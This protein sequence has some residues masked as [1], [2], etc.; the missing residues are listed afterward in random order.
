MI[1]NPENPYAFPAAE[2]MSG[3]YGAY[4][5]QHMGMGLRDWFAGQ[6]LAGMGW[7]AAT[8]TAVENKAKAAYEI[9]DAMLREREKDR[10]GKNEHHS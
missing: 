7:V 9:A 1:R 10:G 3:S 8:P 5:V 4:T 6:A 2:E